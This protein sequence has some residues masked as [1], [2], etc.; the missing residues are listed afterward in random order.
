MRVLGNEDPS[1]WTTRLGFRGAAARRPA[2]PAPHPLQNQPQRW[3]LCVLPTPYY[4]SLLS[5]IH[6]AGRGGALQHA[7]VLRRNIFPLGLVACGDLVRVVR[8]QSW[9][10][11]NCVR[12]MHYDH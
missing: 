1:G 3:G 4:P 12:I 7:G 2:G 9:R 5:L 10:G 6:E 11:S 8:F